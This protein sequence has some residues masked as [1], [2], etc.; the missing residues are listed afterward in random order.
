VGA[1]LRE[2]RVDAELTQSEVARRTGIHRPIIARIERGKHEPSLEVVSTYARA[3]ELDAATV[4]V[5]LDDPW[6]EAGRE[7]A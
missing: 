4:L 7:C 6:I 5:C 1:R 3:L 2:L